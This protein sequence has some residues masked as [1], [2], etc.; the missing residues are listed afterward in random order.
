MIHGAG[1]GGH[2]P[3][4][5]NYE[6]EPAAYIE[7]VREFYHDN[8][9]SVRSAPRTV[10][11]D[12]EHEAAVSAVFAE[13]ACTDPTDQLVTPADTA[14]TQ[15]GFSRVMTLLVKASAKAAEQTTDLQAFSGFD[16]AGQTAIRKQMFSEYVES[17]KFLAFTDIPAKH[18]YLSSV[19]L[20]RNI[21]EMGI[22]IEQN[23][24]LGQRNVINALVRQPATVEEALDERR[25]KIA[26]AIRA[27]PTVGHRTIRSIVLNVPN[28]YEKGVRAYAE[29][30]GLIVDIEEQSEL[31]DTAAFL[32]QFR[33]MARARP[34]GLGGMSA[35][36]EIQEAARQLSEEAL[37]VANPESPMYAAAYDDPEV[38]EAYRQKV[39]LLVKAAHN[40]WRHGELPF[41]P[42]RLPEEFREA[43]YSQ[44][45]DDFLK[46]HMELGEKA[47]DLNRVLYYGP[48]EI[49]QLVAENP[50]I[51]PAYFRHK[52]PH[53]PEEVSASIEQFRARLE[54]IRQANPR[55]LEYEIVRKALINTHVEEAP[56][57]EEPGDKLSPE[58]FIG[59]IRSYLNTAGDIKS[60]SSRQAKEEIIERLA[61]IEARLEA[62]G[63]QYAGLDIPETFRPALMKKIEHFILAASRA[64]RSGQ[65]LTLLAIMIRKNGWRCT[66]SWRKITPA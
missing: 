34:K 37:S 54:E 12:M 39:E 8:A 25:V 32:D 21:N 18:V 44:V 43:L 41:T 7:R 17:C 20:C 4:P 49:R 59:E 28:S 48:E 58:D 23:E 11:A 45:L 33:Q 61:E 14:W 13:E 62:D 60:A 27:F 24:D 1:L 5:I 26:A 65:W 63:W 50:D 3:R 57:P 40:A 15:E 16:E 51:P 10:M 36:E 19:F 47:P 53:D 66:A 9:D 31:P 42:I 22:L 64:Y 6:L 35:P 30:N 46:I 38:Q 55:L 56:E 52:L 29:R 2:E